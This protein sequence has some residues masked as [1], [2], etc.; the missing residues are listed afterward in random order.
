MPDVDAC[1]TKQ[2]SGERPLLIGSLLLGLL[3]FAGILCYHNVT[4]FDIWA[5]L[6][7]GACWWLDGSV[8][9]KDLF[10]F[11]PV[12][13]AWVDHEWGTGVLYYG[14]LRVL[15]PGGLMAWKVLAG[16]GA[17]LCALGAGHRAGVKPAVLLLL[18]IPCAAAIMPGYIPIARP[19]TG[20][21]LFF[22][23]TLLML[24]WIRRGARWPM[25]ALVLMMMAWA[26]MHGGFVAGLGLIGVYTLAEF[27][28]RAIFLPMCLLTA[29]C[30]LV[31]LVNPWGLE[32]WTQLLAALRHDRPHIPEWQGIPL[33]ANDV[34]TGFRILFPLAVILLVAGW[35][36]VASH[37]WA[38]L[39]MMA[40]TAW[41]VFNSRRHAPFFGLTCAAVL[42]PYLEAV[43]RGL[44]DAAAARWNFRVKPALVVLGVHALLV[45]YALTGYVAQSSFNVIAPVGL[46]PVRETDILAASGLK[47]NC[48]V[49]FQWGSYVM[50][51]LHPKVKISVD[52]RYEATYPE[53][54]FLMNL[55]FN[56]KRG[57]W[58]RLLKEHSV[59]F[60]MLDL[61][62]GALRPGDLVPLG[63]TQVW[64]EPDASALLVRNDR[65]EELRGA[66]AGGTFPPPTVQPLDAKI[67]ASWFEGGN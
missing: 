42:G 22:G 43:L 41:L 12:L 65:M 7:L 20:T 24:E 4:D 40:L 17:L 45:V 26:N 44:Q 59:D 48:A 2:S 36:R 38:G 39:V 67:P 60:V 50:W 10:A 61:H 47:G 35:R 64:G 51:R 49:P 34:F 58:D 66:F 63:Y 29:A 14:L 52:G 54:T 3:S 6:S 11:T 57:E 31:T 19:H 15:G 37:H 13:P 55:D 1:P 32:F 33:F 25:P 27:R 21:Y 16:I 9:K 56:F 23:A 18:A 5:R 46:Y 62:G 30:G 28:Q 53:S 8:P